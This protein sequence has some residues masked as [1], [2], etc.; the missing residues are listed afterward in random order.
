MSKRSPLDQQVGVYKWGRQGGYY[1]SRAE[2]LRDVLTANE[3]GDKIKKL[4]KLK[5]KLRSKF[6]YTIEAFT[7]CGNYG[8]APR[9]VD[10]K[11]VQATHQVQLDFDKQR[12]DYKKV[13]KRYS[14]ITAA[15]PSCGGAGYFFLVN[16]ENKKPYEDYFYALV[17]FFR[18][19]GLTVDEAV[20]S[21]NELRYCGLN[22]ETLVR[23]KPVVWKEVKKR[24]KTPI[25]DIVVRGDG[26]VIELPASKLGQMHYQDAV[27]WIAK[28]NHNGTPPKELTNYAKKIG[29]AKIFAPESHLVS[30]GFDELVTKMYEKYATQHG[31]TSTEVSLGPKTTWIEPLAFDEK[32]GAHIHQVQIV[33]E[34]TKKYSFVYS[35][36]VKQYYKYVGTHWQETERSLIEKFLVTAA[37]EIGYDAKKSA[38]LKFRKDIF[39]LFTLHTAGTIQT[40]NTA[41]NL[42]NGILVF[43]DA[44]KSVKFLDHDPKRMFCYVLD[45]DYDTK[46]TAP[47]FEK[48]IART[49]PDVLDQKLFWECI[50]GAFIHRIKLEYSLFLVGGGETGKSTL[51]NVIES[52]FGDA[53]SSFSMRALTSRT[54][55]DRAAREA[56]KIYNKSIALSRDDTGMSESTLWR[57]IASR[58]PISVKTLYSNEFETT[59]YA[60]LVLAVNEKPIIE[61]SHAAQRRLVAIE[62][63]ERIGEE[64]K[65]YQLFQKLV[66]ER[67]GILNYLIEGFK[68][69][70]KSGGT[71]TKSGRAQE[72]KDAIVEASDDVGQWLK[73]RNIKP[74]GEVMGAGTGLGNKALARFTK[75]YEGV[76]VPGSVR[77][78]TLMNMFNEHTSQGNKTEGTYIQWAFSVNGYVGMKYRKFKEQMLIKGYRE[79]ENSTDRKMYVYFFTPK[80]G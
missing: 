37:S 2:K 35:T 61:A 16:T 4:R 5:G 56:F 74:C 6:K 20:S 76:A 62:M 53:C 23:E 12:I 38:S 3:E 47:L 7:P 27:P 55:G 70:M 51:L 17:E 45:Y 1:W 80:T 73:F 57:K 44:D 69:I 68:R 41:F 32:A 24:P 60:R 78:D 18:K 77:G 79:Y 28:N 11:L 63:N 42:R 34:V 67:S 58:E 46:A 49:M 25:T 65:D 50:A 36:K 72:I 10:G 21:V 31:E 30:G 59:N 33:E 26:K 64:E 9:I 39:E 52:L 29:Y 71:F 48:F 15:A 66:E 14:W 22:E 43:N 19:E 75:Q 13:F 8:K 40:D 54:D